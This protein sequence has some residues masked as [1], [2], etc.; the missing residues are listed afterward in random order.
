MMKKMNKNKMKKKKNK[1]IELKEGIMYHIEKVVKEIKRTDPVIPLSA[2][3]TLDVSSAW[4]IDRFY[5]YSSFYH[6]KNKKS[7]INK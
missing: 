7:S 4:L 6:Q 3:G 5:V 2:F 1:N